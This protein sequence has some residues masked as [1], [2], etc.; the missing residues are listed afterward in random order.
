MATRAKITWRG[1]QLNAAINRAVTDVLEEGA[2]KLADYCK[3]AVSEP[4]PP[5]SDPGKP[6]HLRTGTG[7]DNITWLSMPGQATSYVVV[8]EEGRHMIYL[9]IGTRLIAPRPWL[10]PTFNQRQREIRSMIQARLEKVF[11]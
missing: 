11:Q 3:E 4:Y 5:A 10:R 8:L 7:R 2:K 9:E 1:P 6:P